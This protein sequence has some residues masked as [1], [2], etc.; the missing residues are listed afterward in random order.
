[1]YSDAVQSILA[2][3]RNLPAHERVALADEVD[4]I[5]WRD[6]MDSLT[7]RISARDTPD[8]TLTDEDIDRIVDEVRTET[9]LYER[10]WTRLR[11]SAP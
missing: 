11:Q 4:R 3:I 1:M 5:T 9:P 10:Y 2:Q 8:D 6:R 7:Q